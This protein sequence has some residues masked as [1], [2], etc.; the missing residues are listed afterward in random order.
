MKISKKKIA[1]IV[2]FIIFLLDL[3]VPIK[4]ETTN[5][6]N[7]GRRNIFTGP[8]TEK[9]KGNIPNNIDAGICSTTTYGIYLL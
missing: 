5:V 1:L 9:D 4:T 6:C 3:F 2:L 7:Y 8:V